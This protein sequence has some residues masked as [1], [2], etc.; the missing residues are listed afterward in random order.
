M[1]IPAARPKQVNAPEIRGA[2]R[3]HARSNRLNWAMTKNLPGRLTLGGLCLALA[4][5][6]GC[7]TGPKI[8][9][10]ARIGSYTYDQ[11]VIDFGP[12]DRQ[13]KLADG[14]QVVEWLTQRGYAE[15]YYGPYYPYYYDGFR[16]RYYGYYPVP[17]T[18]TMPDVYLHLVFG[19]DGRL[20]SWKRMNR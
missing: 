20:M 8:D 7:A 14:T 6:A 16:H 2:R 12:P 15:T 11:A 1:N 4:L 19:P 5:L 13:A 18:T 17:M 10:N 3:L 9:W